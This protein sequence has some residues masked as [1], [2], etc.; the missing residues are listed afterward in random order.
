MRSDESRPARQRRGRT[1]RRPRLHLEVVRPRGRHDRPAAD[2]GRSSTP[3]SGSSRCP[4]LA[5]HYRVIRV[6]GG[7]NGRSDRPATRRR[8][9]A[10]GVHRRHARRARSHRH[11]AAVVIVAFSRRRRLGPQRSRRSAR[12]NARPRDH[13]PGC[14]AAAVGSHATSRALRRPDPEPT[15]GLGQVQPRHWHAA[16]PR[17]SSSSSSARVLRAA[18]DQ[19]DQ[20]HRRAGRWSTDAATVLEADRAH[21]GSAVTGAGRARGAPARFSSS[22]A[23]TTTCCRR[24]GAGGRAGRAGAARVAW[25]GRRPLPELPRPGA[26]NLLIARLRRGDGAV[27]ALAARPRASSIATASRSAT[28]STATGEP[29]PAR[30]RRH[31]SRHARIWKALLPH[32]ARRVRVVT[33]DGRGN[34]RSGPPAPTSKQHTPPPPT[35]PTSSRC[36]TPP[37]YRPG[38]ARRPLSRLLVGRRVVAPIPSACRPRRHRTRRALPRPAAAALGRAAEHWDDVLDDPSGWELC[39]RHTIAAPS[40]VDWVEFFFGEQ[41]V[42]PHSTKQLED[43]VRV[44]DGVD[45]GD[46]RRERGGPGARP[47]RP[48]AVE[49]QCRDIAVPDAGHPRRTRRLPARS[50]GAAHSPSSRVASSS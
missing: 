32:L 37:R 36:S 1:G 47:P 2:A 8:R 28:R 39:N 19:A 35:S 16:L 44:G 23:A 18:L 22:T 42:E 24:S 13:L 21:L 30:A 29:T 31:R 12:P 7:G 33:L 45:R 38:R 5:R 4:T 49:Q 50:T 46:P 6:N 15:E 43:A 25:R 34:G 48:R 17:G 11:R 40:T 26:V 41:L 20:G 27:R 9:H 14:L 3:A 10:R